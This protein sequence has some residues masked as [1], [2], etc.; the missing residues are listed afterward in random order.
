MK[1]IALMLL[2][3]ALVASLVSCGG[4]SQLQEEP[5]ETKTK[6]VITTVENT[7][8]VETVTKEEVDTYD[9]PTVADP[10]TPEALAALPIANSSMT[11]DQ[12]RQ[13]CLDYFYLQLTFSWTPDSRFSYTIESSGKPVT[14]EKG[15]VFGGIPYVTVG[16]GNLYRVLEDYDTLTGVMPVSLYKANPKLFGNQCSVGAFWGWG[17]VINSANYTWTQSMVKKNGFIPVG[18]YQYRDDLD[19]YLKSSP[20]PLTTIDI[21]Q[22]NG[23][24]V[25]YESYAKMLPADGLVYYS[26][27]AGH[28]RMCSEAPTVVRDANGAI[29]PNQSYLRYRDQV[30]KWSTAEQSDGSEMSIQGGVD[31]KVS[32]Q[33]LFSSSYLPFTFGE[34]I[35]TDPVEPST[36]TLS[37]S[38]DTVTVS[39]L[40]EAV[41]TTNYAISDVFLTVTDE[42]GTEVYEYVKRSTRASVMSVELS[43]MVFENS[44]KKYCDGNHKVSVSCQLSTGE[45]PTV[46]TTTLKN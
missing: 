33:K 37:I 9:Y 23:R 12:L 8:S 41:L 40:K 32:F 27:T 10:L 36:A 4:E 46:L 26:G 11:T 44:L 18:T 35:G 29:D 38:G 6:E 20:D 21:C 43:G 28:V 19:D 30:S 13:L 17:R 1:K 45:K 14:L 7:P 25:M 42:N 22:Q 15:S 3:F 16:T 39:Q 34:L 2:V 31:V 24:D 5:K